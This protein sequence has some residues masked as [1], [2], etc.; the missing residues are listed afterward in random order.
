MEVVQA[1]EAVG[2]AMLAAVA[3]DEHARVADLLAAQRAAAQS[4]VGLVLADDAP[5]R[6]ARALDDPRHD[7][8]EAAEHRL[9]LGR[10]L[11]DAKALVRA[12]R[13]SAPRALLGHGGWSVS[14][15]PEG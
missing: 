15:R 12:H 4:V 5:G 6:P 1:A 8:L 2:D 7:V 10:G 11:G 14:G 9:V 13:R 3:H